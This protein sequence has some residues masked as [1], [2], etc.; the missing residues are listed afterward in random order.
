MATATDPVLAALNDLIEMCNDGAGGYATAADC[1]RNNELKTLFHSY[2][3]Q[4][5]CFAGE[6]KREVR[7]LGGEPPKGG[8]L[9]GVLRRGWTNL[10]AAVTGQDESAVLAECERSEEIALGTYE[11]ALKEDVPG[12]V[13]IVVQ[14]QYADVKEAYHR[15][16]ALMLVLE[17]RSSP[18][19]N[20]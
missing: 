15:V 8:T 14:R 3:E 6:L 13:D 4:R 12:D 10:L 18:V 7:R 16:R 20:P 5:R 1:V 9:V 17:A 2:S 11:A 19:V